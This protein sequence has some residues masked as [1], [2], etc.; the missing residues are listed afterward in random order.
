MVNHSSTVSPDSDSSIAMPQNPAYRSGRNITENNGVN[1]VETVSMQEREAN[2]ITIVL[3]PRKNNTI[4]MT[5]GS[6]HLLIQNQSY[7]SRRNAKQ[8][9]LESV[10]TCKREANHTLVVPPRQHESDS[11][12]VMMTNPS[13]HVRKNFFTKANSELSSTCKRETGN[14]PDASQCY[15]SHST[16][17]GMI[18][19]VACY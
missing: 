2:H 7:H 9:E 1:C 3:P 16:D 17:D 18:Q 5:Q 15:N 14:T 8:D 6:N 12:I 13:Y 10:S 19:N 11:G 4:K